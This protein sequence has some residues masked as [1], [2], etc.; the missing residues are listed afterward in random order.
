MTNAPTS[1]PADWRSLYGFSGNGVQSQ[2]SPQQNDYWNLNV[3]NGSKEA[4]ATNNMPYV[5]NPSLIFANG[6]TPNTTDILHT[7]S[8]DQNMANMFQPK[9]QTGASPMGAS[10][11]MAQILGL[12]QQDPSL[13]Q[14]IIGLMGQG[15][16]T[17]PTS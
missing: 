7:P 2:I 13:L 16:S 10:D 6:Q 17:P 8:R 11:P 12:I 9:A 14:K 4:I 5:M 1:A 3:G 15:G